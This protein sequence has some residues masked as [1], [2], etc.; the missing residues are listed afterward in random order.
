MLQRDMYS[1]THLFLVLKK[2]FLDDKK[3]ILNWR[4]ELEI[5]QYKLENI[6]SY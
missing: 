5:T 6:K 3:K 1:K 2:H 4:S